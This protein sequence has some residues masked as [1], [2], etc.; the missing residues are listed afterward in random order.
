MDEKNIKEIVKQGYGKIAKQGSS[1][2]VSAN[3]CCGT[4]DRTQDISKRIG[5]SEEELKAVPE[6]ANLGLGCGNPVALASL[7]GRRDGSRSWLRRRIRLFSCCQYR[8]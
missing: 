7:T 5:Y 3:S 1:C 2:C 6:G 8:R 4:T